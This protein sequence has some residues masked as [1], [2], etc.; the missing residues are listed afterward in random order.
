MMQLRI[1]LKITGAVGGIGNDK[2]EI[3]NPFLIQDLSLEL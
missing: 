3:H 1:F 2:F